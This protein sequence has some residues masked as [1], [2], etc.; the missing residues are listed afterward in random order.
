MENLKWEE[1]E[2]PMGRKAYFATIGLYNI[3][4]RVDHE[5]S[6]DDNTVYRAAVTDN[7][8][9]SNELIMVNIRTVARAKMLSVKRVITEYNRLLTDATN[10][11]STTMEDMVEGDM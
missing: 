1:Y 10:F 2:T 6:T 7:R 4:I 9:N 5:N 3:T 11:L 8:G